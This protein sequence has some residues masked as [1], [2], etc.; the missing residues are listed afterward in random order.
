M[1]NV[2]SFGLGACSV[3]FVILFLLT[4][5]AVLSGAELTNLVIKNTRDNLEI[6]LTTQG[7]F[8]KD[9]QEAVISGIPVRFSFL[10]LLYEVK[11]FWFDRKLTGMKTFHKIQYDALKKKFEI[12]RDWEQRGS[13]RVKNLDEARVL[14]SEISGLQVISATRLKRGE[15]Y[16]LK[17]KSELGDK[18]YLFSGFPWEFETDWYTINFVY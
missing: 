6:D 5:P 18:K 11:D 13:R 3:I 12:N 14:M 1:G 16:Q 15:H 2:R 8:T 9:M 4:E 7:V 10:I 17:V